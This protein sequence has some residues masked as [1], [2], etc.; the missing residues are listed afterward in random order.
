VIKRSGGSA[1]TISRS[2]ADQ[3]ELTTA[4]LGTTATIGTT[5]CSLI[6]QS[7]GVATWYM[8][9]SKCY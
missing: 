2:G 9:A 3:V 7:D 6:Y 8:L 5:L 1:V 4:G